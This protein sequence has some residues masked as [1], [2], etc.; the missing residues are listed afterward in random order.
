MP[1]FSI[2]RQLGAPQIAGFYTVIGE[3]LAVQVRWPGGGLVWNTPVA[4]HVQRRGHTEIHRIVDGT[5]LVQ[6]ALALIVI[7]MFVWNG[8]QKSG[9]AHE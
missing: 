7:G 8:R 2:R 5:R 4:L 1:W 6:L 9:G 3:S